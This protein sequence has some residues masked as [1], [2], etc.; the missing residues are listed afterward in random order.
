[1]TR[2]N[3][4][5]KSL[6]QR[7]SDAFISTHLMRR[8]VETVECGFG[9]VEMYHTDTF[10]N[11][12]VVPRYSTD[13]AASKQMRDEVKNKAGYTPCSLPRPYLVSST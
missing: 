8:P 12:N 9:I 4:I 11:R 6:T 13:A 5:L 2:S 3:V 7:E 1:M 10:G